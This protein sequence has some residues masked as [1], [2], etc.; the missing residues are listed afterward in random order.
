[1]AAFVVAV[2]G[3]P[4]TDVNREKLALMLAPDLREVA[5]LVTEAHGRLAALHV[6]G[7]GMSGDVLRA[8]LHAE[9]ELDR[10]LDLLL[11]KNRHRG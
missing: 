8:V 6:F 2:P 11:G 9:D 1:M 3:V 4:E 7:E 5:R 10:A